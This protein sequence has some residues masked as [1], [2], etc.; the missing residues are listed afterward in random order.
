VEH[1]KV[2]KIF[3]DNINLIKSAI[4]DLQAAFKLACSDKK[5]DEAD[6]IFHSLEAVNNEKQ[7]K[8]SLFHS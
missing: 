5:F 8:I 6:G 1:A 7:M 4:Q 3:G 2:K